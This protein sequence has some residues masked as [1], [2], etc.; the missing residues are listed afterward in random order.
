MQSMPADVA[1]RLAASPPNRQLA[2][3]DRDP[4]LWARFIGDRDI[5][6]PMIDA[7]RE[8]VVTVSD[9]PQV[10]MLAGRGKVEADLGPLDG[11]SRYTADG[12]SAPP[13]APQPP[14]KPSKPP[15]PPPGEPARGRTPAEAIDASELWLA[16]GFEGADD[17]AGFVASR[18]GVRTFTRFDL[19][20]AIA[21]LI[22]SEAGAA[23][24]EVATA[25][26]AKVFV[27]RT[28]LEDVRRMFR[29]A[30]ARG[31][32]DAL[33]SSAGGVVAENYGS[34]VADSGHAE[35]PAARPPAPAARG[36]RPPSPP[37]ETRPGA[38]RLRLPPDMLAAVSEAHS[39]A[40]ELQGSRLSLEAQTGYSFDARGLE[41]ACSAL[42]RALDALGASPSGG[43]EVRGYDPADAN[44]LERLLELLRSIL[45]R[46]PSLE[47]AGV[48]QYPLQ[49]LREDVAEFL[50]AIRAAGPYDVLQRRAHS[51]MPSVDDNNDNRACRVAE[52]LAERFTKTAIQLSKGNIRATKGGT[53]TIDPGLMNCPVVREVIRELPGRASDM[54][55]LRKRLEDLG[56]IVTQGDQG[57]VQVYCLTRTEGEG[58][59]RTKMCQ[60]FIDA[61]GND[62]KFK[63]E[64]AKN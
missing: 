62:G 24:G 22:N 36:E 57:Q 23:E 5:I 7:G 29:G 45:R 30:G 46:R 38:A 56:M 61:H 58:G 25:F 2:V 4:A 19:A 43:A 15:A 17:P 6:R 1:R 55:A 53:I 16:A 50:Q 11:M 40:Q 32:L 52:R 14:S 54:E 8:L 48:N 21:G 51:D 60:W 31:L 12:F 27:D 47:D 20:E 39:L 42:E 35:R 26:G 3:V 34:M 44:R 49:R 33:L 10:V 37:K 18:L 13:A 41:A 59:A 28:W 63:I 64:C 9:D